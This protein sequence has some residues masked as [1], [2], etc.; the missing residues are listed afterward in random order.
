MQYEMRVIQN[1]SLEG[2]D[3]NKLWCGLTKDD[4]DYSLS[5]RSKVK[6]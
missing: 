5:D 3:D 4:W 2:N 1:E 6:W